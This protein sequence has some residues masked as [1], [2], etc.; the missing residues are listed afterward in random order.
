MNEKKFTPEPKP[1]WKRKDFDLNH[2]QGREPRERAEIETNRDLAKPI[3]QLVCDF[4]DMAEL[5]INPAAAQ[6]ADLNWFLIQAQKRMVSLMGRV[7]IEHERSSKWLVRLTWVLG[8]LTVGLLVGTMILI[9][10]ATHTD[11]E[12]SEIHEIVKKRWEQRGVVEPGSEKIGGIR[13]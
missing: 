6:A 8:F 12:I 5:V 10:S 9:E 13:K 3:E 7:A 2:L 1:D 11:K 4:H